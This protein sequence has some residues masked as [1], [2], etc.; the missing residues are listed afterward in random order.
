MLPGMV[1]RG[2]AKE[3]NDSRAQ[4]S[5]LQAPGN[6]HLGMT[7][8]L[9]SEPFLPFVAFADCIFYCF[10]NTACFSLIEI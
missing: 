9:D 10:C 6:E 7:G 2:C 3:K 1:R 4:I 5:Q 8:P